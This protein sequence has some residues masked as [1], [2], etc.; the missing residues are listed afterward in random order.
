MKPCSNHNKCVEIALHNAENLCLKQQINFTPLRN[1]IL[2]LIWENHIPLTIHE[3]LKKLKENNMDIKPISVYRILD[4]LQ[5]YGLVH[6]LASQNSFIGCSH[7]N[8]SHNCYF[9]ICKKCYKVEEGCENENLFEIHKSLS[10]KKFLPQHITL[11][12]QG[13]CLECQLKN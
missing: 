10:K 5:E 12:I 4:F 8:Q 13:V 3:I 9:I 1:Q 2:Q 11:E 7:P 6:K